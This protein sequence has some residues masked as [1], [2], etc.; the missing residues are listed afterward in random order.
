LGRLN[1]DLVEA[2]PDVPALTWPFVAEVVILAVD[3]DMKPIKVKCRKATG[4]TYERDA[5][6]D[7]ARPDLR[8]P[9]RTGWRRAGR[10]GFGD[11][12]RRRP[13]F[14]RRAVE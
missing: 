11:G 4:G 10:T 5:D 1:P 12:G 2:D 7:G 14:Q 8:R 3:H 13:R 9:R 6:G